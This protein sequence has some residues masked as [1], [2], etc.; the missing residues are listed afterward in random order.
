MG[1]LSRP[2]AARGLV[3]GAVA[4]L[5]LGLARLVLALRA[6]RLTVL[7]DEIGFL[8]DAWLL[9]RGQPAPPMGFAPFYPAGQPLVLS[10]LAAFIG[11]PARLQTAARVVDVV[12]LAAMVPVLV[13]LL[14]R[15]V[16]LDLERRV[17]AATLAAAIPGLWVAA[18]IVWPDALA[19]LLW[20]VALV[21]LAALAGSG[22]LV[23]RIWFGPTVATLWLVH[24]RFLPVVALGALVLVARL[25]RPAPSA[26]GPATGGPLGPR[27]ADALNLLLGALVLVVG[28]A[29]NR[30][31]ALR[32]D[33]IAP[34]PL[35]GATDDLGA[36]AGGASGSIVGQ[37][38]YAAVATAGLAAVGVGS[39]GRLVWRVRRRGRALWTEP[40]P[41]VATVALLGWVG[42]V[43]ATA[44][45]LRSPAAFGSRPLLDLVANGRYQEVVLAPL[46][47]VG[48][49]RLLRR[50][51]DTSIEVAVGVG[52]VAM[53][54]VVTAIVGLT[55]EVLTGS[56]AAGITWATGWWTTVPVVIPTLA[57][58]AVLAAT[59]AGRPGPQRGL[60]VVV[61][62]LVAFTAI[63]VERA[64]EVVALSREPSSIDADITRVR[65]RAAGDPVAYLDEPSTLVFLTPMGWG[66]AEEGMTT[67]PPGG[68]PPADLVVT[69]AREAAAPTPGVLPAGSRLSSTLPS[70]DLALWVV[71]GPVADR[72]GEAGLL[73]PE[74]PLPASARVFEVELV[75][76][77][78]RED[79]GGSPLRVRVRHAG[80]GAMWPGSRGSDPVRLVITDQ[81]GAALGLPVGELDP[82]ASR[83][84]EVPAS[85]AADA[86]GAGRQT[87]TADV[88]TETGP[89]FTAEGAALEVT[90]DVP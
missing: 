20:P 87:V 74:G 52:A 18:V 80:T 79:L 6:E 85:A 27:T 42:V 36:T 83:V 59:R 35:S 66:L 26:P 8:G 53:A 75:R 50:V 29:L 72:L 84:I 76:G 14:G 3:L 31:V 62:V 45:Q 28:V 32:W 81:D 37:V 57:T 24:A 40:Q 44:I 12:L 78:G 71:P 54:A 33:R 2:A 19:A 13:I 69:S 30:H 17:L 41:L 64:G 5:A 63:G 67:F 49:A 7:P 77:E 73:Y 38:W 16:H 34:G 22:R 25:V 61:A 56:S 58:V 86:F 4:T 47:A 9:G 90:I 43:L 55:P 88:G 60:A 89:A 70:G 21:A 48:A 39:M 23:G 65:Q 82:G 68:E 1:R 51:A 10:P 46:V 11:D 15:L